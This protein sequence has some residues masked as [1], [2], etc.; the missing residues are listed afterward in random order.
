[1]LQ[2]E[3]RFRTDAIY[4]ERYVACMREYIELGH[5]VRV[6]TTEDGM[7]TRNG[8]EVQFNTSYLPHHA[9]IKESSS[10]T[11]LRVVF[12]ASRKTTTGIS[13]NDTMLIGPTIQQDIV[14]I[15]LR[16]RKYSVVFS[17]DIQ[18]MYRQIWVRDQDAELQRI[19][20]RENENAPIFDYKLTTVTFGTASAP[21]LATRTL[22]QR[23]M[24]EKEEHPK[25]A[26][27]IIEDTYMDDSCSGTWNVREAIHLQKQL[28]EILAG[29]GFG[30]RKWTSNN[31][32][33]LMAV[34]KEVREVQPEEFNNIEM[35]KV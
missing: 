34:N 3:K 2:L 23:A 11:K 12:D 24:E 35:L 18:K 9:V 13:L 30:L 8:D 15:L 20:W 6:T 16:W 21:Y 26:N 33:F 17:A 25:A 5:M 27:I 22:Q 29:A 32:E 14:S 10:T 7:M 4:K 19:V 31:I 1:M 28:K